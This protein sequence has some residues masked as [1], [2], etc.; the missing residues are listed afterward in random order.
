M[1]NAAEPR[2]AALCDALEVRTGWHQHLWSSSSKSCLLAVFAGLQADGFELLVLGSASAKHQI[3]GCLSQGMVLIPRIDSQRLE[4]LPRS[5]EA[6]PQL[7]LGFSF[8]F[9]PSV[10]VLSHTL[11]FACD[12]P[13]DVRIPVTRFH[14]TVV[15]R[16]VM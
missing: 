16:A 6:V 15:T 9:S 5:T 1:R 4:P 2:P 7:Y 14:A 11:L 8:I 10:C 12:V 3:R 13:A